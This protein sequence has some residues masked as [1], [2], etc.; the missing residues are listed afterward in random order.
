MDMKPGDFA[1]FP[2]QA[3]DAQGSLYAEVGLTKREWMATT[4]AAGQMGRMSLSEVIG[5]AD[6]LLARL[7]VKPVDDAPMHSRSPP[8]TNEGEI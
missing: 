5:L 2:I 1:A 7:N 8:D 3:S 6:E 4:I